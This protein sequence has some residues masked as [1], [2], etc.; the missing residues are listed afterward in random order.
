MPHKQGF[1]HRCALAF[2]HSKSRRPF[3]CGAPR[4]LLHDAAPGRASGASGQPTP[5]GVQMSLMQEFKEFA[6]RG[7]VVD[8][9]VGVVIGGAVGT[10][11]SSFVGDI[12]KP[13]LGKDQEA[14]VKALRTN[15]AYLQREVAHRV[16]LKYAAKL[17]FLAD[18]SFEEGSHIDQLLRDP[19]VA[20]DL[21][22]SDDA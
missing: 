13:L 8:M 1:Q 19:K 14:V 20:R 15:T 3:F 10:I 11:V 21:D 4:I 5:G 2:T 9:A 16:R 12:V 6:V 18:D 17:K 22:G 7:N